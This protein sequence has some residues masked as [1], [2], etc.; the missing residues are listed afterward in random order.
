MSKPATKVKLT[1]EVAATLQNWCRASTTEQRLALRAR[2]VLAA[3]RNETT[4]SIA[5]REKIR[6]A[7]V[8]KWR[9]RFAQQGLPGLQ[10][11]PRPGPQRRWLRTA[12]PR[13]FRQLEYP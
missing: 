9:Q 1:P 7:T 5:H 13:D 2:I 8:S 3:S 12:H 10:D 6:V 11:V 4:T